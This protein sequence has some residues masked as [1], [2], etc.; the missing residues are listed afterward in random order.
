MSNRIV[1]VLK[2]LYYIDFTVRVSFRY[3]FRVNREL[4]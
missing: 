4:I 2:I 3:S 1:V